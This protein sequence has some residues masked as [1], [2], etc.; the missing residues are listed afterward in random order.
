V[1]WHFFFETLAY[2]VA[3]RIYLAQRK[4]VGD[5]LGDSTRWSIIAAAFMGAV[6]GAK[7]LYLAEDPAATARHW[8]DFSYLL[9][10]KTIVGALAGGTIAVELMKWRAGI[11]RRT[12]D[13]FAIPLAVGIAIG[14]IGCFLAGKEDDTYGLPTTLPWGID[15]GDGVRRHPVQLYEILFLIALAFL[16]ARISPAKDAR[17]SDG[18]TR[19]A[20]GDRFRAF[21]LAYFA[22]R[23][24]IDFLKPGIHLA[25]LTALQWT[26][27]TGI[28]CYTPDLLRMLSF[29][30]RKAESKEMIANG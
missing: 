29:E 10:G 30:N 17:A 14:R 24:L 12:G 28:L 18:S 13:L 11:Q 2:T 3:F 7:L 27:A 26:C 15:L 1:R 25:G 9:G 4:S 16:L 8:R 23:L 5:F 19:F 22:W 21:M 20:E 6:L